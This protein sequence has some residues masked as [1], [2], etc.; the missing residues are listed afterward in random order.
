MNFPNLLEIVGVVGIAGAAAFIIFY[1]I[2]DRKTGAAENLEYLF[3][4]WQTL[5]GFAISL[6]I[7]R[8]KSA[9]GLVHE[10]SFG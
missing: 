7:K 5:V 2:T 9:N 3:I 6:G 1:F 8:T 10:Q 4:L